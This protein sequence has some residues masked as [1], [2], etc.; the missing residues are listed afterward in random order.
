MLNVFATQNKVPLISGRAT[1]VSGKWQ[2]AS[3]E[4]AS[5]LVAS[6]MHTLQLLHLSVSGKWRD[7]KHA[8]G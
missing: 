2:V 5:M 4:M 7:G 6:G 3:G 8:S 1:T